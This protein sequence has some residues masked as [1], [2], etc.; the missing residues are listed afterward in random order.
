VLRL[1]ELLLWTLFITLIFVKSTV[2]D[3]EPVFRIR[4][5]GK[6]VPYRLVSFDGVN[7]H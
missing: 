7:F 4:C 6:D 5:K 1:P 2:L 3:T